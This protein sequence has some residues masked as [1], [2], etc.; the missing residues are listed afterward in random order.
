MTRS[1]F[2][3]ILPV[4]ALAGPARGIDPDSEA[5][6]AFAFA[7][8]AR[9]RA[10]V[11]VAPIAPPD[12][13]RIDADAAPTP[14]SEIARVLALL[15]K[16]TIGFVDFGCGSDARWCLAAAE[17]W[18][19]RVTGVE[20]DP[21][22]A[23]AAKE[24]VRA[25][26]LGYL[27]AIVEGDAITT[28]VEADVGVAYLWPDV[29]EKLKPRIEKL[30]A[31]ASYIHQPPVTSV[32]NGDSWIYT[33]PQPVPATRVMRTTAAVWGG[34]T[35]TGPLCNSSRCSM[36]QSIRSQLAQ[37]VEVSVPDP[38]PVTYT[39]PSYGVS[40]CAGGNCSKGTCSGG[41]CSQS[42]GRG[43]ILGRWRN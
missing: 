40:N 22:R 31:F 17:R 33:R 34:Q 13:A 9:E 24:S 38:D 35:Y 12:A 7:K 8:A 2:L 14:Q 4:L 1:P 37:A 27:I 11:L 18:G 3:A 43:G 21:A 15:P 32:H 5:A 29:L 20:I 36:C 30:Q 28:N 26:G 19:C 6:A 42:S 10:P 23:A 16:P 39:L 25:A 41:N